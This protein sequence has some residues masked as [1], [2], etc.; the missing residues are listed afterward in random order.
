M[1][2]ENYQSNNCKLGSVCIQIAMGHWGTGVDGNV[3]YLD[4]END[5]RSVH[6]YQ[7]LSNFMLKM[8]PFHHENIPQKCLLTQK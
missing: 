4:H 2:P 3:L 6:M 1:K 5:H 8:R 7:N